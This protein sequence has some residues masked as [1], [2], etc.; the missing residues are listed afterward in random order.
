MKIKFFSSWW[1]LD[2]LGFDKMIRL[3]IENGFDG[4][5]SYVPFEETKKKQF[6]QIL[7]KYNCE[8]I[9]HQFQAEGACFSDF[10]ESYRNSLINA[11]SI[12]PL[13]INSHT[14]KDFWDIDKNS[15]LLNLAFEVSKATGINIYHE[16]HRG[17]FPYSAQV[18]KEYLILFPQL[19]ITADFSHWVCVSESLLEDQVEAM[20]I[21]IER[22]SHIHARVGYE[23]GP[24]IFDPRLKEWK[25]Y[26]DHFVSWWKKIVEYNDKSGFKEISIT[27]EFGPLPYTW[28][29]PSEKQQKELEFFEINVWMKD[30]L[31]NILFT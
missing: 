15:V 20:D 5:E 28:N 26:L 3:V 29:L 9:A 8:L 19:R 18:A 16:T 25:F 22:T 21:A 31:K 10:C 30:Y 7:E 12:K 23:Q 13:F 27:P 4:I 24:Q 14:G 11:A 6:E 17:R 1:G 2:H